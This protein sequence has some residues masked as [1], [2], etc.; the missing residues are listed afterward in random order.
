MD[1]IYSDDQDRPIRFEDLREM[2][3]L[4]KCIKETLR[5]FPPVMFIARNI[6]E[7]FK[8]KDTV[9]PVGTTCMVLFYQLHRDPKYFP[10]PEKFDPERFSLD[11]MSG[12]HAFA[13]TPFSA[14]PRNCIGQ[15]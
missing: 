3:Y 11:K 6:R 5:I 7:Q 10:N 13:Y 12:R 9:I 1:S 8:I 15:R 14:G 4:E 2:K